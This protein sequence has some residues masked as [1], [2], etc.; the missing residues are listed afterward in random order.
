MTYLLLVAAVIIVVLATVAA[1]L[2]YKVYQK[3]RARAAQQAQLEEHSAAQRERVNKSI[4]II[5]RS[6]G[7]DEITLTEASMRISVLLDSLGVDEGVREEFQAFY[8]LSDATAHIP[9]LDAWKA[10]P[11]KEKRKHDRERTT[12]EQFHEKGVL[13]ASKRILGRS[14]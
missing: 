12:Q 3:N 2:Q 5:A 11:T 6:V 10:L 8:Q 7:S 14:F 4:Q 1:I 9:I 13:D